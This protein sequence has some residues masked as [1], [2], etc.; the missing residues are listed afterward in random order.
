MNVTRLNVAPSE[1]LPGCP[2]SYAALYLFGA[3]MAQSLAALTDAN[4]ALDH[5][6]QVESTSQQL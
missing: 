3:T 6:L 1:M 4:L 2:A 5:C